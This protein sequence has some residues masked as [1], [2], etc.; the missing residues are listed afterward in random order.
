M[1]D[2]AKVIG[3]KAQNLMESLSMDRV[4]DYMFH[5]I[6]EYSKLQDFKPVP[7]SSAQ[8]VCPESLLCFADEKKRQFLEKSTVFPYKTSNNLKMKF[9]KIKCTTVSKKKKS[10]MQLH[11]TKDRQCLCTKNREPLLKKINKQKDRDIL[12]LN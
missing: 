11:F 5:L 3:K 4:Y 1:A 8:E 10:K 2:Q 6:T 7:P 12:F 9:Q